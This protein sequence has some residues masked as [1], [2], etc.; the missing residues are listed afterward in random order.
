[1][2]ATGSVGA[3]ASQLNYLQLEPIPEQLEEERRPS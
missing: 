1:M 2:D 3:S